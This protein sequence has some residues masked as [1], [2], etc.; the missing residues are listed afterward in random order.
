MLDAYAL[1]YDAHHQQK[2][3]TLPKT[4][5]MP[6]CTIAHVNSAIAYKELTTDLE[7]VT[8]WYSCALA[9][10]AQANMGTQ[11]RVKPGPH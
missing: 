1:C 11:S 8:F 3:S 2:L 9:M 4:W 6:N 5:V 10:T 7:Q